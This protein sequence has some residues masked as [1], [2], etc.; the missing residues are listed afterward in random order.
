M[1]KL[2]KQYIKIPNDKKI[3]DNV[4]KSR[5]ILSLIVT[6]SCIAVMI[7]TAFAFFRID[8][9]KNYAMRSAVWNIEVVETSYGRVSS[10]Y[11]CTR[12]PQEDEMHKFILS[13]RGTASKGFCVII[14]TN[15]DGDIEKYYTNSF[16]DKIA[17]SIQAVA[18]CKIK[19]VPKWGTPNNY[20]HINTCGGT[21]Y[22]SHTPP[23]P[24]LEETSDEDGEASKPSKSTESEDSSSS[25]SASSEPDTSSDKTDTSG[26]KTE[27]SDSGKSSKESEEKS[28]AEHSSGASDKDS[29]STE[30]S[31]HSESDKTTETSTPSQSSSD[32]DSSSAESSSSSSTASGLDNSSTPSSS[33]S[34]GN[35]ETSSSS[36]ATSSSDDGSDE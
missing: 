5:V 36:S 9:E 22:H 12:T 20:G 15:P 24:P 35:S 29:S 7:S 3:S 27:S 4:L 28:S 1:K 32:N 30:T 18:G 16:T 6:L 2:Y 11:E 31:T 34:S 19:F 25:G 13:S 21:I 26:S 8:M 17:V 14:I 33:S 23:P 10:V